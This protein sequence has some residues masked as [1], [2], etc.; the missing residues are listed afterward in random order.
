MLPHNNRTHVPAVDWTSR[1]MLSR[2]IFNQWNR[3]PG[4]WGN[5]S[6]LVTVKLAVVRTWRSWSTLMLPSVM[7][8]WVASGPPNTAIISPSRLMTS[9]WV[10]TVRTRAASS[11]VTSSGGT[12][13]ASVT[14]RVVNSRIT[15][16]VLSA[17]SVTV[18]VTVYVPGTW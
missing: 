18:S 13:P 14:S 6:G 12:W 7:P 10:V 15:V 4:R 17:A 2:L 3:S 8:W 9:I 11:E 5:R 1:Q 16:T